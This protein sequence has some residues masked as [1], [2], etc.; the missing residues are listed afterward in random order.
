MD[1]AHN[2][3]VVGL[4]DDEGYVHS[5]V[6]EMLNRYSAEKDVKINLIHYDSARQLFEKNDNLDV[7]LLD[8]DMPETDGIEAGHKIRK[9]N[10]EYKIIMLTAC[11]DRFRDAFKIGA[12]RF[13]S[14]P[15]DR[16]ELF[17]A[18]DDVR[19]S[20]VAF[21]KVD[22]YRDGIKYSIA[23][24]DISYV[25]SN[26]SAT[27]VFTLHSEFRSEKALADWFATLNR[28]IFFQCHKSFIVNMGMVED[29]QKNVIYMVNGDKVALSRRLRV[30]FMNAYMVYDTRWR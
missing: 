12:Y 27:L 25:E 4:C 8:I 22:V 9:R 16:A 10:I 26:G 14:K 23:Q 6:E 17:R 28:Q 3:L 21:Q 5:Y 19:E 1:T 15:V 29:I 20:M 24:K 18:M 13:V 30:P 11:T 7:L 2:E